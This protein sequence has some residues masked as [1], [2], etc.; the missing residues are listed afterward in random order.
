MNFETVTDWDDVRVTSFELRRSA[1]NICEKGMVWP[2]FNDPKSA[3][4]VVGQ[5]GS[6]IF[7]KHCQWLRGRRGGTIQEQISIAGVEKENERK[8]LERVGKSKGAD[9]TH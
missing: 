5:K 2:Q 3:G 8:E 4:A 1:T 6:L 7:G 9:I